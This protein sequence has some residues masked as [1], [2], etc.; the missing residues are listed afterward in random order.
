MG[1]SLAVPL[2]DALWSIA[3]G[4][5]T[6]SG[7]MV[8]Y[9]LGSRVVPAAESALLSNIEVMLAPLWGLALPERIRQPP[10]PS[11][12]AQSCWSPSR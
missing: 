11:S 9:E 6:L 5:V 3:M 8:L 12:A 4:A 10:P 7:G 2:P 1:Q